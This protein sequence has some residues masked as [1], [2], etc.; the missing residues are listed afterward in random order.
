MT[1][2]LTAVYDGKVLR[3]ERPLDLPTN[4]RYVL[5][6]IPIPNGTEDKRSAWDVITP[7]RGKKKAK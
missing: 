1:V 7:K 5:T 3:P 6:L 4:A 2:T